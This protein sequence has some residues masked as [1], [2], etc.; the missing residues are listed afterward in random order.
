MGPRSG[1][2][3]PPLPMAPEQAE[4]R[5]HTEPIDRSALRRQ[6]APPPLGGPGPA[7]AGPQG[8]GPLPGPGPAAPTSG[9]TMTVEAV[10]GAIY[11]TRH[12]GIAILLVVV[13]VV[14]ELLSAR[15]LLTGEFGHPFQPAAVLAGMFTMVGIPLVT[16]GLYGLMTGAATAAGPSPGR[17]WLRTPLALLP[18]GLVLI[19][20]ASLAG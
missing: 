4:P 12:T 6:P 13:A 14:A 16:M 5:F 1:V 2:E 8:P 19:V 9:P 11:R 7:Q 10:G 18:I 15:I 20:A 17:A 3:L